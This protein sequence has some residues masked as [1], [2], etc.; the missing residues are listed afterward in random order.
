MHGLEVPEYGAYESM[1]WDEPQKGMAAMGS[2]LDRDVGRLLDQLRSLGLADDTLVLFSSG[3]GPH[4]EGGRVPEFFASSGPLRGIKR[5]LYEG[6]IQ[7]PFIA[8][9]PDTIAP[10][11]TSGHPSAFWDF[12]ATAGEV[13]GIDVPQTDGMSYL[14]M[15]LGE[16]QASHDYLY[17]L[18]FKIAGPT[19]PR[20]GHDANLYG[21]S[22][23][24]HSGV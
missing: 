16:H 12:L 4:R 1:D 6:G 19:H 22:D 21:S 3:N 14:A 8:W 20:I 18:Q 23:Q 9:W 13:T 10:S 7:V 15:L 2:R 17:N 24:R 5:D 11:T